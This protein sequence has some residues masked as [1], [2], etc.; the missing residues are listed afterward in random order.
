[1]TDLERALRAIDEGDCLYRPHIIVPW[2]QKAADRISELEDAL[3]RIERLPRAP[4]TDMA[5]SDEQQLTDVRSALRVAS[6]LAK[7]ALGETN[8]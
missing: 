8:R 1:M 6:T 7:Q 3:R 4:I 2:V 5:D